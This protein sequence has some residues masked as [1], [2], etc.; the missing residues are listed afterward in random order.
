MGG[1]RT[2]SEKDPVLDPIHSDS[3]S[4]RGQEEGSG[5]TLVLFGI[6]QKQA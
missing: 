3:F 4:G 5:C 6:S 1:L 2:C